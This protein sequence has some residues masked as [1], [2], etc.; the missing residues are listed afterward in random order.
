MKE[1]KMKARKIQ[2][3]SYLRSN[4]IWWDGSILRDLDQEDQI[5]Q[6]LKNN[7]QY[8]SYKKYIDCGVSGYTLI[9]NRPKGSRLLI[10]ALKGKFDAVLVTRI[11]RI[12][13]N[14][15]VIS[16]A[17]DLFSKLGIK[18]ISIMEIPNIDNP[19][20]EEISNLMT[21]IARIGKGIKE[22]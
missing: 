14:F 11:D 6:F 10:D 17:L 21:I 5:K 22:H 12:G 2:V 16:K 15:K 9:E 1:E 13:E 20:G 3:A 4:E 7:Q 8:I 19:I 18:L